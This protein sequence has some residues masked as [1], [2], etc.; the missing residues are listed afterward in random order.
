MAAVF[1]SDL[2]L[3]PERPSIVRLFE[4]FLRGPARKTESL[5]ILGDLF[6][7]WA[8]DD[9]LSDPFNGQVLQSL[10][11]CADH[12]TRIF[13]LRGNRDFLVGDDFARAGGL[14]LLEDPSHIA[15]DDGQAHLSHGDA[16]C[17]GDA[18]YQVFRAKVRS[19]AWQREFLVR[20]LSERKTEIETLRARSEAEKRVKSSTIMD[21]NEA[22]VLDFFRNQDCTR[23]IHGHTHRPAHHRQIVDGAIRDRWVLADWYDCGSY[24]LC[25]QNGIQPLP[26]AGE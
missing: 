11:D 15:L 3:S 21:V 7:Y 6:E 17:T 1:I 2:H 22:A 23:L 5:Y 9:D 25:D 13:F 12:G 20:P 4:G 10:A 19:P 26:W 14:T 16:L 24:L 18:E 8:G